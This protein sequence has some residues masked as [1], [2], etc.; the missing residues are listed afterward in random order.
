MIDSRK[1]FDSLKARYP[2]RVRGTLLFS[3]LLVIGLAVAFPRFVSEQFTE[4]AVQKENDMFEVDVPLVEAFEP[5]PPPVRPSIPV[6]SDRED[7]A[8]DVTIENT[9]FEDFEIWVQPPPLPEEGPNSPFVAYDKEPEPVGGWGVIMKNL[10]YP[11]IAQ[12]AGIE[13]RV[14]VEAFVDEKG[15]VLRTTVVEGIPNTG[16]NEAAMT[17]IK[18]TRFKPAMQRER[19]VGVN[20][21]IDV[22]FKLK[23]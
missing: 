2:L 21:T 13:G 1:N 22:V 17:A 19:P 7:L 16:L 20:I 3:L 18:K 4:I 14:K 15:R 5:P 9:E 12:E 8:D 10:V 11:P 23:G 6:A